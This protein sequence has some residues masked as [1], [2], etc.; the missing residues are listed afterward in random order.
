MNEN[1]GTPEPIE[2]YYNTLDADDETNIPA[3]PV[4]PPAAPSPKKG[5]SGSK[6]NFWVWTVVIVAIV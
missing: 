6:K 3:A 5:K 1:A 2:D 4:N